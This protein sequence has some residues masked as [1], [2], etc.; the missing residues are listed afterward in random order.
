[1]A[2]SIKLGSNTFLDES[3]IEIDSSNANRQTLAGYRGTTRGFITKSASA[4][5]SMSF[6]LGSYAHYLIVLNGSGNETK[7]ILIVATN[8]SYA[9]SYIP[10]LSTPNI[11][12]TTGTGTI[13]LTNNSAYS[14]AAYCFTFNGEKAT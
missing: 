14:L 3:G 10:V 8:S 9:V 2:Q 12:I 6:T 5:T 13:T 11:A 1:M 7:N 4:N